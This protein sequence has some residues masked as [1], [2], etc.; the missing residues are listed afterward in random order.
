MNVFRIAIIHIILLL[1]VTTS[2]AVIIPKLYTEVGQT[3]S[4]TS[5][6]LKTALIS[7]FTLAS[8]TFQ[9]GIVSNIVDY[10]PSALSSIRLL[11]EKEIR[12]KKK[13]I[14][15]STVYLWN[16]PCTMIREH[17]LA[18]LVGAKHQKLAAI[19]GTHFRKLYAHNNSKNA[20]FENWNLLYDVN[21]WLKATPKVWNIGIGMSNMDYF[22]FNQET[23]PHFYLSS[24]YKLTN[25]LKLSI[26]G[27]YKSAGALNGSVH[28]YG[29]YIR[30]GIS[31]IINKKNSHDRKN[32]T[33]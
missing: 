30:T 11:A 12:V 26:D 14:N 22:L 29:Y 6:Y 7:D 18:F 13:K 28:Y 27:R 10:Y 19:L 3:Q 4:A 2:Y 5:P 17:N 33:K 24:Y 8:Y 31:C 9:S 20:I 21:Y 15:I 32:L 23:N 1:W 25:A 16:K